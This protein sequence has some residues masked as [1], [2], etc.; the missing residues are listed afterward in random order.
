MKNF[1]K[2]SLKLLGVALLL[3]IFWTANE[4]YGNP[5]I[6]QRAVQTAKTHL[7]ENYPEHSFEIT[8]VGRTKSNSYIISVASQNSIDTY[9]ELDVSDDGTLLYDTYK[10]TVVGGNNTYQRYSD[11]YHQL[12]KSAFAAAD[13]S[14]PDEPSA[15]FDFIFLDDISYLQVDGQYDVLELAAQYGELYYAD[16]MCSLNSYEEAA[17][18]LLTMK[19][20]MD[21][22]GLPFVHASL[23]QA[24]KPGLEDGSYLR[25]Y[26]FPTVEIY[27][28]N[29]AERLQIHAETSAHLME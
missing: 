14:Y 4:I 24:T 26:N 11:E 18:C 8:N 7:A 25:I 17:E 1:T 23:M 21:D 5:F 10:E 13:F 28:E 9:F 22:A 27:E 20:V 29:L 16:E 15:H 3:L 6:K 19:Q 12:A 2:T